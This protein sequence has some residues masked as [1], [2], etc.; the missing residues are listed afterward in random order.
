ME[1]ILFSYYRT[2]KENEILGLKK[3]VEELKDQLE[4]SQLKITELNNLLN[5]PRDLNKNL[6]NCVVDK[7]PTTTILVTTKVITNEVIRKTQTPAPKLTLLLVNNNNVV[8]ERVMVRRKALYEVLNGQPR[9]FKVVIDKK[10]FFTKGNGKEFSDGNSS[11]NKFLKKSIKAAT[12]DNRRS[13]SAYD[14]KRGVQ[15]RHLNGTWEFLG[16]CYKETTE[17]ID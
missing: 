9:D 3:T 11:L 15:I 8:R 5:P 16:A 10:D 13:I 1:D 6:I 2:G 17:I 14:E 4:K 12:G 7:P